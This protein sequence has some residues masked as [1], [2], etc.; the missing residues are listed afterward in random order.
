MNSLN[1]QKKIL[2]LEKDDDVLQLADE[3]MFY[4]FSDICITS[5]SDAIY[6]TARHF[7]P[8]LI[9]LDYLLVNH[10]ISA[11]CHTL[12][13]SPEFKNIPIIIISALLNKRLDLTQCNCDAMFIKPLDGDEIASRINCLMAS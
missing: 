5:D 9:I 10:Q 12:K 4:G 8:D 11:I 3:I 2:L 13:Q 6:E 1:T 7:Q